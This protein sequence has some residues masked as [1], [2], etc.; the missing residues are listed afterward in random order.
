MEEDDK[1]KE[2]ILNN[3]ASTERRSET[4][5]KNECQYGQRTLYTCLKMP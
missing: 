4:R 2:I 3:V 1:V 5:E